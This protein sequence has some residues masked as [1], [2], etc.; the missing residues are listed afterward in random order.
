[1]KQAAQIKRDE[2]VASPCVNVCKMNESTGLCEGCKR[3]IDEIACW[4]IYT[5]DEKRAV[6]EQLPAR[7][8]PG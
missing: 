4:S 7:R 2:E 6:L 1:M 5:A 8:T 3:T